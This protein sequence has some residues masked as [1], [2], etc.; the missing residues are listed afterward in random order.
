MVVVV[1]IHPLDFHLLLPHLVAVQHV[2]VIVIVV[3][4]V[5]CHLLDI[6]YIPSEVTTGETIGIVWMSYSC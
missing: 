4:T 1:K 6:W 5:P 3:A 2:V